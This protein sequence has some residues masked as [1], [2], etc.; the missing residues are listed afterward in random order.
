M[1]EQGKVKMYTIATIVRMGFSR[2]YI[3]RAFVKGWLKGSKMAM[4]NNA[5][6]KQ[7]C[8]T[9][10]QFLA[11]RKRCDSHSNRG[12][13]LGTAKDLDRLSEFLRA[14]KPEQIE[15]IKQS[16]AKAIDH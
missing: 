5:N 15:A 8:C 6:I 14:A 1:T 10:E 11:W 4:P 7:W 12:A 3:H 9:E 13:F 16:L 2:V